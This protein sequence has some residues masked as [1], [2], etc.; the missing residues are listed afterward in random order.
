VGGH[1]FLERNGEAMKHIK[2]GTRRSFFDVLASTRSAQ[3]AVMVL[4]P[5][6]STGEP[7]NE[8]PWAEQWLFVVSGSGR[9]LVNKRRLAIRANSLLLIEKGEVHQVTNTGRRPLITLNFYAP[10]AYTKDGELRE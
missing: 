7:E 9:A 8:H 10:P 3:A 6:Q 4:R 2:T 5:G 1:K